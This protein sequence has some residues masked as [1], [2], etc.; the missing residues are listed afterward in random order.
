MV[1]GI[2]VGGTKTKAALF[3][4][5]GEIVRQVV[6]TSAHPMN[7]DDASIEKALRTCLLDET[8]PV[9]FGYAG[10]GKNAEMKQHIHRLVDRVCQNRPYVLLNDIEMAMLSTLGMK[11]GICVIL[12][13]GSIAL[14][15]KGTALERRGGWGY[16]LGDEGSGYAL[17][18][19]LLRLFTRQADHRGTPS[20]LYQEIMHLYDL[21]DPSDLIGKIMENGMVNRTLVAR[22][23]SLCDNK[24]VFE[25]VYPLMKEQAR[26]AADM[27]SSFREEGM[28]VVITGG[29]SHNATY[30][31][32]LGEYLKD[33]EVA[34]HEPVYGAYVYARNKEEENNVHSHNL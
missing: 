25:E 24:E 4:E 26:Q 2:D 30:M 8:S 15:R 16:V 5:K 11:D 10:Y 6:T 13:T 22:C 21:K 20:F 23:A 14:K 29:M 33:F 1:I 34:V 19:D 7:S 12:G 32:V 31:S 28:P 17:G 9:V 27:I 3:D 18:R